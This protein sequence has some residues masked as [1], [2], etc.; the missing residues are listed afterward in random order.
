MAGVVHVNAPSHTVPSTTICHEI[1]GGVRLRPIA[2]LA[3][4]GRIGA[5]GRV[6][7]KITSKMARIVGR[8]EMLQ[9]TTG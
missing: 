3:V 7:T 4:A 2:G 8:V 1:G 9:T 5:N 6:L